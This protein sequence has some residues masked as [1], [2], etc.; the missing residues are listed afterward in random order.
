MEDWRLT[1]LPWLV[2]GLFFGNL[3]LAW[4][5]GRGELRRAEAREAQAEWE[6]ARRRFRGALGDG[7]TSCPWQG[8]ARGR[9]LAA[10]TEWKALLATVNTLHASLSRRLRE[11]SDLAS[12]GTPAA[13]REAAAKLDE[14]ALTELHDAR[15]ALRV[16][17]EVLADAT[18]ASRRTAELD[19]PAAQYTLAAEAVG[20]C[21]LPSW[22]L[23]DHPLAPEPRAVQEGLDALRGHDPLAYI[24]AVRAVREQLLLWR[25]DHLRLLASADAVHRLA[26]TAHEALATV[27]PGTPPEDPRACFDQARNERKRAREALAAHDLVAAREAFERAAAELR[28]VIALA[29]VIAKAPERAPRAVT[30]LQRQIGSQRTTLDATL[31]ELEGNVL[32]HLDEL[33]EQARAAQAESEAVLALAVAAIEEGRPVDATLHIRTLEGLPTEPLTGLRTLASDLRALADL[34][35]DDPRRDKR[36]D[37][38]RQRTLRAAGRDGVVVDL[39]VAAGDDLRDTDADAALC[40]WTVTWLQARVHWRQTSTES[41]LSRAKAHRR[42]AP[43]EPDAV[44]PRLGHLPYG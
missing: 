33:L 1:V 31:A 29:P 24:P 21:Q 4:W 11:A 30:A 3:A 32:P 9:T 8:E 42:Q 27:P 20:R 26:T 10:V 23:T 14:E 16:Q 41:R 15:L 2:G 6:D 17:D 7:T 34:P 28:D 5:R 13:L 18:L 12:R 44:L 36:L 37:T 35:T 38:A 25:R 40:A 19:L 43:P 39:P 22:V